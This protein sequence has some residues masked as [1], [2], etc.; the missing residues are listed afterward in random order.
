MD[1]SKNRSEWCQTLT[2]SV[3]G[4]LNLEKTDNKKILKSFLG[5]IQYL[6]KY[7]ANRSAQTDI[8]GQKMKKDNV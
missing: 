2:R 5:A 8:L 4:N 7:I 3:A 6:F 1:W